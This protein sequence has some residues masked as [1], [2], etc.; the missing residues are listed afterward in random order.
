MFRSTST[1]TAPGGTTFATKE[2]FIAELE[3][4]YDEFKYINGFNN[5]VTDGKII[6]R[7]Y[8]LNAPDVLEM[9]IEWTDEADYD[10]FYVDSSAS[11]ERL[12]RGQIRG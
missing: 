1:I 11:V 6:G 4:Y 10:A 9:V 8:T 5:F 12:R 7:T 3:N 2:E